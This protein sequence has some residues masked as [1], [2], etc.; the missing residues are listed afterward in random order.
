MYFE[1]LVVTGSTDGIGKEYAKEL[2]K[3]DIN[4]ILISRSIDK[5]NKTENE[6]R[7]L[8]PHIQVKTIQVDFS[9]GKD[10]FEKIKSGLK[11]IPIGILGEK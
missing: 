3:R 4:V 2:A 10:E 8:N 6:I 7:I 11:D 5:L 1:L 9:R